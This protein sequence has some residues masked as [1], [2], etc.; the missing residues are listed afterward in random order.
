[1][2]SKFLFCKCNIVTITH[3]AITFE[4]YYG[5]VTNTNKFTY[6]ENIGAHNYMRYVCIGGH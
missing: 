2:G 1:M 3:L 4:L 6:N 5:N